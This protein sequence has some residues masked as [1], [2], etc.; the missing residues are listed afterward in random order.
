MLK[1][2]R[3][4]V[5]NALKSLENPDS[6]K[7]VLQV[8]CLRL[9]RNEMINLGKEALNNTLE[10]FENPDSAKF[11]MFR[12]K[13][14]LK[15]KLQ[16]KTAIQSKSTHQKTDKKKDK[17]S[18]SSSRS[19]IIFSPTGRTEGKAPVFSRAPCTVR[20]GTVRYATVRYDS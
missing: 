8:C 10:S 11:I 2:L 1:L 3:E 16:K 12:G 9:V 17:N 19:R 15:Q 4:G 13:V 5:K 20:Y 18:S 6:V 7:L 14:Q